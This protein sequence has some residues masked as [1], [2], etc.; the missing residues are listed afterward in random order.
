MKNVLKHFSA[1]F[2]SFP[3]KTLFITFLVYLSIGNSCVFATESNLWINAYKGR[4]TNVFMAD[5]RSIALIKETVPYK[6][7]MVTINALGGPPEPMENQKDRYFFAAAC[8]WKE[9]EIKGFFWFDSELSVAIGGYFKE[10]N[11]YL[12]SNH[13]PVDHIPTNAIKK[14]REWARQNKTL[15]KEVKFYTAKGMPQSLSAREFSFENI[16]VN[17]TSGPSFDCKNNITQI[18]SEIC[19]SPQ[20]SLADLELSQLVDELRSAHSSEQTRDE[21]KTLQQIW[22]HSRA[23]ECGTSKHVRD[24]LKEKYTDRLKFLKNWTPEKKVEASLP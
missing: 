23:V 15:I 16:V 24:C 1:E 8:A 20:L 10:G 14:I 2:Y 11:L 7:S 12:G 3:I 4:S 9:C 17:N 18:E 6:I 22:L 5:K 19:N 21:L 13:I